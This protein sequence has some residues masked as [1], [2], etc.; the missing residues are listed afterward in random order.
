MTARRSHLRRAGAPARAALVGAIHLY[1]ATLS[2]WLGGQCRF[3]PT[4][5]QYA[6]D[7]IVVHGAMHG[8]AL[9]CWRILRCNPYARHWGH[10]P[11]PGGP[12]YEYDATIQSARRAEADR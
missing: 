4:C 7:A 3:F 10:D 6:E 2:G 9:A 11:V 8:S 1:R 5:S 12:T